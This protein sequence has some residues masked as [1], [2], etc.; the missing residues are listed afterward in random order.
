MPS[1]GWYYRLSQF[2]REEFGEKVYKIPLETGVSC[3]N[4]DGTLSST[5]CIYCY[6]PGFSSAVQQKQEEKCRQKSIRE[7]IIAYQYR[8]ERQNAYRTPGK[9]SRKEKKPFSS[10][11]SV[12]KTADFIPSRKYLAYF[13]TYS[14]TYA[15]LS[16]LQEIYEEALKTPGVVGLS[17]ATRPDCLGEEVLELLGGYAQNYHIWLELGLQSAHDRTLQFIN[18]GHDY[19]CFQEALLQSSGRG[20]YTCAHII[21]GLP[22]ENRADMLETIMKINELPLRGVKFHQLQIIKNTA[23]ENLYG[24]GKIEVLDWEEYLEIVCEQ[25]EFLKPDKV[26]H[27]LLGEVYRDDLLLA[28]RWNV[29][30]GTFAQAVEKKLQARQSYQGKNT[31]L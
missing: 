27:R 21:N 2:F 23:L 26:V 7:Q 11:E 12:G 22:G 10:S 20:L 5:G 17:I 16:Y 19:Q 25:L 3:P 18:R 15:S 29:F 24:E 13:Q 8:L 28:P 1:F 31:G 4:R 9:L 30:R 14:N 6:N